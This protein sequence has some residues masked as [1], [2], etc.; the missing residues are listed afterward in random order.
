M[1]IRILFALATVV[2]LAECNNKTNTA[3]GDNR[4][5][6]TLTGKVKYPQEGMII[7]ETDDQGSLKSVD[8][9]PLR[10]DSSFT[11][12]LAKQEP[13]F[14]RLNFY[15]QQYVNLILDSE[16]VELVVDG[17]GKSGAF[18]VKGSKD[19]DYLNEVNDIM[20]NFNAKVSTLNSEFMQAKNAGE[21]IK[22]KDIEEKYKTIQAE[23]SEVIKSKIRGMGNSLAAL[24]SANYL[25]ADEEFLFLDSL[26]NKFAQSKADSKI[27]KSYKEFIENIRPT[28]IGQQAPELNL[29]TPDGNTISLSSLKGKYV[30]IDFWASWCKPCREENPNVVKMYNKYKEKGFE[31]YGVSLDQGKEEWVDAIKKD[32]LTWL[33]VSDLKHFQSEAA[34][35]YKISA[36]PYTVLIDKD[37]KIIGK[38]LR[39]KALEDKLAKIMG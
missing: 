37:G 24:Y 27:Y 20:K 7:L 30:L 21:E 3:D 8:T 6:I 14:Y 17:N 25:N 15:N 39:G 33:H 19:T 32:G 26:S 31:I 22:A 2:L 12:T 18:E 13:G 36:I 34:A 11:Y 28:A 4:E 35:K 10:S 9:I 38:N 23:N 29:P 16:D 5:G 1:T